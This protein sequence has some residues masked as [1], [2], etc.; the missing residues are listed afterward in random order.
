MS[1]IAILRDKD[2]RVHH[3]ARDS[4][5]AR[6]GLA[7]GSLVDVQEEQN[8]AADAANRDDLNARTLDAG[9]GDGERASGTTDDGDSEGVAKSK[10]R[11]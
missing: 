6:D 9:S 5:F 10:A 8:A 4:K 3:T 1:D 11:R 2:G 7:D